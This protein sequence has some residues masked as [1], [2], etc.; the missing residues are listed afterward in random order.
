VG[1]A[2]KLLLLVAGLAA[3]PGHAPSGTSLE[4]TRAG[5]TIDWGE[6]TL[7]AP[8]GAAADLHMPSADLARPGAERRARAAALAQ[9]KQ[10]LLVLPLGGGRTL[11]PEAVETALARARAA[12][13][14]YQSNGGAVIRLRVRFGDWLPAEPTAGPVLAIDE[15]HLAASPALRIAGKEIA[16]GVARYRLGAPPAGT[17]PVAVKVDREGRW[18]A[19]AD[20]ADKDLGDKL[21]GTAIVI[22][23][24]KVL[25]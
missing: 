6:G 3:H 7:T 21:S 24:Q 19:K 1:V 25:R 4:E 17:R 11:S 12:D 9:L 8:G 15:I 18:V 20:K 14:E 16:S 13:I 23:V 22:Y 5:V 10:A 2:A